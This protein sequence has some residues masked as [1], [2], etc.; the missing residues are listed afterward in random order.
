M[1]HSSNFDRTDWL[2]I[3]LYDWTSDGSMFAFFKSGVMYATLKTSGPVD[4]DLLRSSV[5]NGAARSTTAFRCLVGSGSSA[6]LLS[7]SERTSLTTS[8]TQ[9][10]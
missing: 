2:E 8:S 6:Q 3:G 1:S 9:T 5:M 10:G 7:G 4:M